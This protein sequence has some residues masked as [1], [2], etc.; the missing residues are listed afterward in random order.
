MMTRT[1]KISSLL[2][3]YPL[4][5]FCTFIK[6]EFYLNTKHPQWSALNIDKLLFQSRIVIHIFRGFVAPNIVCLQ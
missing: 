4:A 6:D 2:T 3:F 1:F 5:V